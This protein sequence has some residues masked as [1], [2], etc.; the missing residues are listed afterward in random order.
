MRATLPTRAPVHGIAAR[1][2][3]SYRHKQTGTLML[4]GLGVG[5]IATAVVSA[6]V[7]ARQ[8]SLVVVPAVVMFVL[9][10]CMLLFA[11]LTVEVD[12]ERVRLAFGPG[13]IHKEFR[14]RD[15]RAARAVRN[16][17]YYGWGIRLTPHGWLF[18]VAGADAV[19]L[20]FDSGRK[21]RIGTD[22]PEVLAR[23]VQEATR[24]TA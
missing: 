12:R 3:S 1:S 9:L 14:V 24:R 5:V 16:P 6:L 17:W 7:G 20:E 18:N 2:M 13:V 11:S 15:I 4:L 23:A 21:V 22:E 19:E 8:P 10:V